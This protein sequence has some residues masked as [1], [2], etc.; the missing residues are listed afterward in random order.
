[1]KPNKNLFGAV[2]LLPPVI[3]ISVAA[4]LSSC[5][6]APARMIIRPEQPLLPQT[7]PPEGPGAGYQIINFRGS[8]TGAAIPLWVSR[9]FDQGRAGV[10][11]LENYQ[12]KYV[13]I[14]TNRG[15]N[16]KALLQWA[17]MFSAAQDFPA[18]AAE[19]VERRLLNAASLYPDDE[20]GEFF[21]ALVKSAFDAEYRGAVREEDFWVR[22]QAVDSDD[23]PS[24]CFLVLISIDKNLLKTIVSGLMG[25]I[26]L[27]VPPTRDQAASINRIRENFFEGF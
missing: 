16:F 17:V 15:I 23:E 27:T 19:R 24:Y 11:T 3:F 21:E 6:N 26:V 9:Y 13:F 10:E 25:D 8:E 5:V 12:D 20:Y 2:F 7:E 22:R 18:L 1:M 4:L 14:G